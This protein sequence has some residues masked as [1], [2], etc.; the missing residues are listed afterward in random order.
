ME[1]KRDMWLW[2]PR[3]LRPVV[4]FSTVPVLIIVAACYPA[5]GPEA[6]Y[7]LFAGL[8]GP[9]LALVY[10]VVGRKVRELKASLSSE[11]GESAE[12]LIVVGAVQSPGIA[13]LSDR[14]LRL[15]PIVGKE[16]TLELSR[17]Q[18]V[19]EA[20]F[21]NGKSLIWKRW[22]VLSVNPRLGFALPPPIA[23]RWLEAIHGAAAGVAGSQGSGVG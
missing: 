5:M 8:T 14:T 17:I 16:V 20:A 9:I 15:V 3:L 19:Q 10:G 2:D 1:R 23:H 13:I 6:L 11:E 22:L 18:S 7:L 21:F 4:I 12:S